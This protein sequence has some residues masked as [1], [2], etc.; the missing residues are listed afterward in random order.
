MRVCANFS[1]V[2]APS[3]MPNFLCTKQLKKFQKSSF[4][5]YVGEVLIEN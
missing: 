4:L 5:P 3:G 1:P 2:L